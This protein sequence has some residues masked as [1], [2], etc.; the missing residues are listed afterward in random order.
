MGSTFIS[1][2]IIHKVGLMLGSDHLYL[3]D[4]EN[5]WN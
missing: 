2:E 3:A 1:L 4:Q 5:K